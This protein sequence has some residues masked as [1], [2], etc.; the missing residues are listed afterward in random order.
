MEE[1][2]GYTYSEIDWDKNRGDGHIHSVYVGPS[3]GLVFEKLYINFL[4]LGS[5]N[6][7]DINRKIQFPGINR[8][9]SNTHHSYDILGRIDGGYKF[10]INTGGTQNKPY[11]IIP[12]VSVS[13]LN[14]FEEGYNESGADSINLSVDS[15]YS[16]FL[17]PN[18][19]IKLLREVCTPSWCITPSF[20]AG[21][22]S[23]IPLSSRNY[24]ANLYKQKLCQPNFV[25]KSFH[26]A[27]NQLSVGM[28]LYLRSISDWIVDINVKTDCLDKSFVTSG[29][30]KIE[31]RF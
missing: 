3:L 28:G 10:R 6:H 21:W 29:N 11:F 2:F 24:K 9:A 7:Y 12:E 23:N 15:K 4:A 8:T 27:T 22:I 26:R 17:Q 30:L 5:Y 16:A 19:L 18:V 13:Y 14:V 1:G 20:H 31:K 25:V